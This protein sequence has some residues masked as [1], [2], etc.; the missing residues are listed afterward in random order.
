MAAVT[1]QLSF[2]VTVSTT[3]DKPY[4]LARKFTTLDHLTKGRIAWNAVT[5]H[6]D[7]AA[8]NFGLDE[9][10]PH[11]ERYALAEEFLE[12]TYKLWEGSWRE[13]AV[14]KSG[15]QYTVPGRV[16]SINHHG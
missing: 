1:T 10:I 9:Q 14:V 3:Y 2:V 8:R 7:G 5:S 15:Q 12:A 13:D 16:R 6:L 4:P 11:D